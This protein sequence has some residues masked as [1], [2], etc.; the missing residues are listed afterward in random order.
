MKIIHKGSD[1]YKYLAMVILTLL[2]VIYYASLGIMII[3][4]AVIVFEIST[5]IGELVGHI[6]LY[7]YSL[8]WGF[9]SLHWPT[10]T[11]ILLVIAILLILFW[12]QENP[13]YSQQLRIPIVGARVECIQSLAI[14]SNVG[15]Y[16]KIHSF[17]S[18]YIYCQFD[19][20]L[21]LRSWRRESWFSA[22]KYI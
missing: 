13:V 7:I 1:S 9:I 8:G 10:F 14:P 22:V 15:R 3:V 21:G 12:P 4:S 18:N 16:G 11:I 20:L 5:W 19:G 2:Q 6:G 17:D